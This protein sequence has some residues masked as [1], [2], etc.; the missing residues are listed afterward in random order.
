MADTFGRF[1]SRAKKAVGRAVMRGRIFQGNILFDRFWTQR[2]VLERLQVEVMRGVAGQLL[3]R[4]VRGV[5]RSGRRG[6]EWEG[7]TGN[8]G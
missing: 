6:G 8:F 2:G 3:R 1:G 5:G 7:E 4:M